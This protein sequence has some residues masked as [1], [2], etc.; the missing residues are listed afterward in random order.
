MA[1]ENLTIYGNITLSNTLHKVTTLQKRIKIP[2]D[3]DICDVCVITKMRNKIPKQ[4]SIWP[5]TILDLI[6]FDVA[7]LFL[8]T[9]RGNK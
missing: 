1:S 2:R 3:L 9:I 5:T 8:A 6:Q 4:L 7:G